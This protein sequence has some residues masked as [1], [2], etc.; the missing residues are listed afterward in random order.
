M[1]KCL[2]TTGLCL[3]K[4]KEVS[5][6]GKGASVTKVCVRY[7]SCIPNIITYISELKLLVLIPRTLVNNMK[8][9]KFNR[10]ISLKGKGGIFQE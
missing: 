10:V 7:R 1:Y 5:F 6:T 3:S 9:S 2:S 4:E 8:M